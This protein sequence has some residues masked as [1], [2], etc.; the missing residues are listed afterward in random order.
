ML[1]NHLLTYM[2]IIILSHGINFTIFT[3]SFLKHTKRLYSIPSD[4]QNNNVGCGNH[5][6][7]SECRESEV[8]H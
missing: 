6:N 8:K 5:E 3:K 1:F 4:A 2:L 7:R